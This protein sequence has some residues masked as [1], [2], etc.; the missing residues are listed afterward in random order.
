MFIPTCFGD[1]KYN[2]VIKISEMLSFLPVTI[3]SVTIGSSFLFQIISAI[4]TLKTFNSLHFF[5]GLYSAI[6]V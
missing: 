4:K 6:L 1:L 5:H 3:S 2:S